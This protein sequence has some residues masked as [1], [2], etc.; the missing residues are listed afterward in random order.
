[1]FKSEYCTFLL[2]F[3]LVTNNNRNFANDSTN[4]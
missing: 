4:L 1:M 2:F 3:L